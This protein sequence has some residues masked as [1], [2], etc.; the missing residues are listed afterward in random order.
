MDEALCYRDLGLLPEALEKGEEAKRLLQSSSPCLPFIEF[1]LGCLYEL[2]DEIEVAVREFRSALKTLGD[3]EASSHVD[4][5]GLRHELHHRL[6]A[7]LLV[8]GNHQKRWN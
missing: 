1:S 4:D 8:T 6:A 2:S 3:L 5:I 7:A